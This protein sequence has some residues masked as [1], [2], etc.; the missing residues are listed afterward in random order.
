M[1]ERRPRSGGRGVG[2]AN[3]QIRCA[4]YGRMETTEEFVEKVRAEIGVVVIAAT[5]SLRVKRFGLKQRG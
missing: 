1:G 4:V 2:F 3:L 5:A